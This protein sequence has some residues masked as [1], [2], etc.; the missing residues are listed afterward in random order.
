MELSSLIG[1]NTLLIG[2]VLVGGIL[3]YKFVIQPIMNENKPIEPTEEDV[4]T[5]G[6]KMQENMD[7]NV[8]F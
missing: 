6:E 5:F 1:N 8:D 7:P 3:L 2:V 4:K